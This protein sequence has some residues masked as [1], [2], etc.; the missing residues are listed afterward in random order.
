MVKIITDTS[1][2][3]TIE[4]GKALNLHVLPLCVSILGEQYRDLAIDTKTFVEKIKQGGIPSSSQPPI[5]EVIEAFEL[6]DGEE[7]IN[8]CMADGLSGTYQSALGAREEAKNKEDIHV[9]NSEILCGP[10][11]YLVQ[12][13]LK[14]ANAG[15]N[16]KKILSELAYSIEECGSFLIPQDFDFL[17]RGGR[18]KPAASVIGGLLKL[19]PIM[20]QVE[21]GTRLDKYGIKRTMSGVSNSII[22]YYKEIKISAK[23]KIYISH[24]F[25]LEAAE[26]I[27]KTIQEAFPETE[28]EM[29]E[30]S[31]AFIT[32]GGPGCVAIQYIRK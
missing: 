11:R 29:L 27:K 18:L 12:K 4:E 5:G 21:H 28:I 19:K 7:I 16:A 32:Q 8:I 25:A 3:Y 17:K 13:A 24:A 31:A 2:L 14:L 22:E 26:G 10:Q 6:Y 1:A 20:Q 23:H 30:L 15:E 9:V